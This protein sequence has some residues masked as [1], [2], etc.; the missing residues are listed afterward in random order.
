MGFNS[1]FKGFKRVAY[2]NTCCISNGVTLQCVELTDIYERLTERLVV[3]SRNGICSLRTSHYRLFANIFNTCA[4]LREIIWKFAAST[5]QF[6]TLI[7]RTFILYR[8]LLCKMCLT[9]YCG[10][11][12]IT[13]SSENLCW[14]SLH[15]RLCKW[16]HSYR[17]FYWNS[18]F[19]TSDNYRQSS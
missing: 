3:S 11:R 13:F 5:A 1:G 6:R 18:K 16:H 14:H 17:P 9:G 4:W 7:P 10:C 2:M 8:L 19:W 15:Q 12:H